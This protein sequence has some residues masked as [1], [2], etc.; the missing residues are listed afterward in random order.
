[1]ADNY[2]VEPIAPF[3]MAVGAAFGTFTANQDVSP[4]PRPIIG[5]GKLHLGSKIEVEAWGEY[6]TTLTPTLQLGF[7]YGTTAVM[8]AQSAA[9]TTPSGAAAF[10]WHLKYCG[11]VVALGAT[12]SIV[13]HG[14]VDFGT[15]L[16]A[17][18]TTPMPVTAA[19]RTVAIDTTTAK[20]IGVA[21]AY[22]AS[23]ASNT[24]KTNDL[25]VMVLN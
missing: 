23:S 20:E 7:Y 4:F 16:T 11:V 25:R 21:A 8:L 2:Y 14:I 9:I 5:G 12:G 13:G 3:H 6:S 19:A 15:S 18:S 10:Q 24:V 1:M 22:S 17:M